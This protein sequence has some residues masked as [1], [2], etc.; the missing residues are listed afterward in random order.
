MVEAIISNQTVLG[1]LS[2]LALFSIWTII[3]IV[4]SKIR[5]RKLEE[6]QIRRV[7]HFLTTHSKLLHEKRKLGNS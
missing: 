1:I 3:M 2:V 6:L 5:K 7:R 4:H